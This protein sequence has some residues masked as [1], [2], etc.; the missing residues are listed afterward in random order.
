MP[1]PIFRFLCS[2]RLFFYHK[3]TLLQS[4]PFSVAAKINTC[5]YI[6]ALSSYNTSNKISVSYNKEKERRLKKAEVHKTQTS[7]SAERKRASERGREREKKEVLRKTNQRKTI[8]NNN[9]RTYES[10]W[11]SLKCACLA[12][13]V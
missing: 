1:L 10:I 7:K 6:F 3:Y 13:S 12:C 5:T 8:V 9:S 11:V 4:K 2:H